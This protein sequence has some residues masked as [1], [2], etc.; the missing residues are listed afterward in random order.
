MPKLSSGL[1]IGISRQRIMEPD[2][3]WFKAPEGHFWYWGEDREE[4]IS[5]PDARGEEVPL[6]A[7]H[8]PIPTSVDEVKQYVVVF[9]GPSEDEMYWAGDYLSNF[10]TYTTV[11]SEDVEEFAAWIE[12]ERVQDS[13]RLAIEECRAQS[14][15]NRE[16]SGFVVIDQKVEGQF[17][18]KRIVP[19]SNNRE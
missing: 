2:L 3:N 15:A 16:A 18:S 11:T 12:S 6:E 8:A 4:G 17:G 1:C 9:S 13:L 5:P 14:V 10:P 7:R 19:P